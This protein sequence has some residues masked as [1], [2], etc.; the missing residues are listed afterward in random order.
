MDQRDAE[1][2]VIG[3]GRLAGQNAA[4]FDLRHVLQDIAD[5]GQISWSVDGLEVAMPD[6]RNYKVVILAP[7]VVLGD[8][9]PPCLD[10]L[11]MSPGVPT[12]SEGRRVGDEC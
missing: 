8:V 5:D 10:G 6:V 11:P 12:I 3:P 9:R 4:G 2:D 1:N 7:K